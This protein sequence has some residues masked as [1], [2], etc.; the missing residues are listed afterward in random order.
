MNDKQQKWHDYV[1]EYAEPGCEEDAR[2]LVNEGC[3]YQDR[4]DYDSAYVESVMPR[5]EG[6]I[7]KDRWENFKAGIERE[8]DLLNRAG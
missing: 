6:V 4:G 7:R 8:I 2:A 3:A 1:M 5:Y